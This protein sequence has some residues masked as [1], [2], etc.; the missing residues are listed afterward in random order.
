M[1]FCF[2]CILGITNT[3]GLE[4]DCAQRLTCN[5]T[6]RRTASGRASAAEGERQCRRHETIQWIVERRERADI[7]GSPGR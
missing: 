2:V 7:H 6:Q 5:M 1:V 3:R 4:L